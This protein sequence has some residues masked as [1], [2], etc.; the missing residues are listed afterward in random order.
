[1]NSKGKLL[2]I[3]SKLEVKIEKNIPDFF[4]FKKELTDKYGHEFVKILREGF[5]TQLK[6]LNEITDF[7]L[8][9]VVDNNFIFSQI[10]WLIE[11]KASVES[12][13]AYKLIN[14]DYIDGLS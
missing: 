10:R 9:I 4:N 6:D 1:M 3:K 12:S 2:E 7:R 11:N 8:L 5:K 14:S 13:L